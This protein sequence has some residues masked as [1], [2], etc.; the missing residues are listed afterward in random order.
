MDWLKRRPPP[1]VIAIFI[2]AS[3]ALAALLTWLVDQ[4][5]AGRTILLVSVVLAGLPIILSPI[6][7]ILRGNFSV[8]LLAVLSIVT[9][10][11]DQ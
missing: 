7:Q 1:T 11:S 2:S 5:Q 6:A 10:G 4:P 9:S 8:D 3:M